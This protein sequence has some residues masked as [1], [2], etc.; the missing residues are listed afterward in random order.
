MDATVPSRRLTPLIVLV[1]M[2]LFLTV[3][4]SAGGNT[5]RGP[6]P[7]AA[8]PPAASSDAAVTLELTQVLSD[9]PDQLIAWAAEAQRRSGGSI[10]FDV[11]GNYG[12]GD[13]GDPELRLVAEVQAGTVDMAWVGARALPGFDA[14]LAPMLVD[15]HD[16]QEAVFERGIPER[17]LADLEVSG[18]TGLG[19]LPGPMRRMIGVNH[20][21]RTPHDFAG[22]TV[23]TDNTALS[24]T[25]MDALGVQRVV[26]GVDETPLDDLSGLVGH[27][28]AVLG[29]GYERTAQSFTANL[30]LWPR[31]LA[32]LINTSVFEGLAPEQQE[33]LTTAATGALTDLM[34]ATRSEDLQPGRPD[35]LPALCSSALTLIEVTDA[36][37]AALR[38]A[39]D[40]VY[41]QLAQDADA[42][43]YVAEIQ[44]LKDRLG[45]AP[46]NLTCDGAG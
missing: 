19:V 45:A 33:A 16:L 30:N 9:M 10:A 14:L 34:A 35:L 12:R 20:D 11:A 26:Q 7:A 25:T 42:A 17:M 1:V 29:N 2:A 31:P 38:K 23:M 44:A 36:D 22:T 37:L 5:G 3:G 13:D 18:V 32:L 24:R 6:A 46:A 41:S 21:F 40:P 28:G 27:V 15:S 8:S 4:C 43:A 39:V